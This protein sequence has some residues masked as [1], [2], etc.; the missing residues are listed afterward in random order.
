MMLRTSRRPVSPEHPDTDLK[1]TGF[2]VA[3]P[4]LWLEI[5]VAAFHSAAFK[6][7]HISQVCTRAS[8]N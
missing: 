3:L 8:N 2:S 7:T 6:E 5:K 1:L 4:S